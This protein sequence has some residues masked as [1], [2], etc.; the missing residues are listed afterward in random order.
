MSHVN[1][2]ELSAL[3]D[4]ELS[5]ERA[6]EV[7]RALESDP[8]LVRELETLRRLDGRLKKAASQH[9]A[10]RVNLPGAA[11]SQQE[12][13]SRLSVFATLTMLLLARFVPKFSDLTVIV[14]AV[15]I[16]AVAVILVVIARLLAEPKGST[17]SMT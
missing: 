4:G 14:I 16:L 12:A 8:I 6:I 9:H 10:L 11:H 1:P 13:S 15:E 3:L 2:E 5:D 17:V 7:Q